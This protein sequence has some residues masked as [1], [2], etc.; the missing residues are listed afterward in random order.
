MVLGVLFLGSA[1]SIWIVVRLL[2]GRI[3]GGAAF[4]WTRFWLLVVVG[5]AS[6]AAYGLNFWLPFPLRRYY[7]LK[8][9]SIAYDAGFNSKASFNRIFKQK[10]GITPSQYF[11]KEVVGSTESA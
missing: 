11:E 5:G 6:L 10:T 8:L 7:N 9:I 1:L 4:S 2:R 3:D